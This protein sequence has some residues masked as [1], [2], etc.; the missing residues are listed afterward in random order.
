[1]LFLALLSVIATATKTNLST[2]YK[3]GHLDYEEPVGWTVRVILI[4]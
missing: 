1:M 3:N 2:T 4:L